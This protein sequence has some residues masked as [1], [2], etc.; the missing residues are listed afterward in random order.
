MASSAWSWSPSSALLRCPFCPGWWGSRHSHLP[1]A[2]DRRCTPSSAWRRRRWVLLGYTS[3]QTLDGRG[4]AHGR[5]SGTGGR[6]LHAW[7][8]V[9]VLGS[10]A[11]TFFAV[12]LP[13][14][15]RGR[16]HSVFAHNLP[17]AEKF[18]L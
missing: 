4:L 10:G 16:C 11:G 9:R 17:L 6:R 7:R 8:R 2:R 5:I 13:F 15:G 18:K 3:M 1:A 14:Q 12:S